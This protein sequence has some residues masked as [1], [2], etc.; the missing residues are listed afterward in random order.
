VAGS[1]VQRTGPLLLALL[2]LGLW[3]L[4]ALLLVG[5]PEHVFVSDV[6]VDDAIYFAAPARHLL[7]GYGYSFDKLEPSN[8][9]QALWALV[10]L[11]LATLFEDRLLLLRAMA[12]VSGLCWLASAGVLFGTLRAH[13][14]SAAWIGFCGLA[15]AGLSQRLAFQGMENGC[16]RCSP[17]SCSGR[18]CAGCEEDTHARPRW[19]SASYSRSSR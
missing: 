3:L 13:S 15:A 7:D 16:T 9:V 12:L 19:S 8:G 18:G 5:K 17:R 6:L 1:L 14:R 2:L 4:A 10:T 11:L